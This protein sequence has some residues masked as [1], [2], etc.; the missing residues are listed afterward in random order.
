MAHHDADY[1]KET[2][3]GPLVRAMASMVTEQPRDAVEY[4]GKYLLAYVEREETKAHQA[5]LFARA[6]EAA[7]AEQAMHEEEAKRQAEA[8]AEASKPAEGEE[9]VKQLLAQSTEPEDMYPAV[10]ELIK[11]GT[12]ATSAYIGIKAVSDANVPTIVFFC[13]SE[14]SH[15]EGKAL[16]G[17]S[18]EDDEAQPDGVSFDAFKQIEVPEGEDEGE[19]EDNDEGADGEAK[20]PQGPQYVDQVIVDNVVRSENVKFFGIPKLGSYAAIPLRY[21]SCLHEEGFG[22]PE[23][24]AEG[25]A[26]ED[27][28]LFSPNLKQVEMVIGMHTMGQAG[29]KFTEKQ[30]NFAKDFA[31]QLAS[32]MERAEMAHW[33]EALARHSAEKEANQE[34]SAAVDQAKT[35]AEA[36]AAEEET[37]LAESLLPESKEREVKRL[38]FQAAKDTLAVG[39]ERL[40]SFSTQRM[41]P[42]PEV[43]RV[44]QALLYSLGVEKDSFV[45]SATGKVNW[46]KARKAVTEELWEKLSAFT[47]DDLGTPVPKYAKVEALRQLLEVEGEGLSSAGPVVPLLHDLLVK[48]LDLREAASAA[49]EAEDAAAAAAAAEEEED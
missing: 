14:G 31:G 5:E 41:T 45:T 32:A 9:E 11:R 17:A 23:P 33:Q 7:H 48:S 34:L 24:P 44:F 37:K 35:D 46:D 40:L 1:L 12:E 43:V 25:T 42:K 18:P 39:K 38:G 29:R 21:Q 26:P 3:G 49:K 16:R 10:V 30:L 6:T 20:K 4:V 8:E 36:K 15:M 22:A 2:V 19:G 28:P 47:P 13:G 27:A